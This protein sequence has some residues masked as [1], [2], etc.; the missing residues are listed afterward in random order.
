MRDCSTA[1]SPTSAHLFP[2]IMFRSCVQ[3]VS[4]TWLAS[5]RKEKKIPTMNVK[6]PDRL[7]KSDRLNYIVSRMRLN[8]DITPTK[9]AEELH[10]SERTIYR[11]LRF[12]EKGNAL[13]K[14]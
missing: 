6:H 1:C 10:V 8:Q 9:L 12:L 14:R 7:Y 11:D 2:Y 3:P 5:A 4:S 13:K